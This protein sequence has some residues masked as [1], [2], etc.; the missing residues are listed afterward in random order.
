MT[1][2]LDAR[3]G[4]SDVNALEDLMLI[5]LTRRYKCIDLKIRVRVR[6]QF[7]VQVQDLCGDCGVVVWGVLTLSCA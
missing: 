4:R 3:D 7:Q 6:V 1:C 2:V 5:H